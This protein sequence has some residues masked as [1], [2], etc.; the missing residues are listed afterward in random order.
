MKKKIKSIKKYILVTGG[1]GFVGS[2][3]IKNL[4]NQ[5]NHDVI[6]LDNYSTGSK[7]NHILSNKVIYLNDDTK[8][9]SKI[10]SKYKKKIDC[11][12]H[13]G[14]FSRVYQSFSKLEDC[15]D[16]NLKGTSEV[17]KFCLKNKIKVIYSATSASLGNNG[18]DKNLSPYAY[19]KS[20]NLDLLYNLNKWYG[21]KYNAIYFYNV[22]GPK[23][24]S[25]GF[26]ATVIGIFERQYK[27]NQSLTVVRPG[28][29]VRKF[30]NIEDIINGCLFVWKKNSNGHFSISENESYSII[31]IAKM[32]KRKII[33]IKSRVGERYKSHVKKFDGKNTI[34]NIKTKYKIKDYI[35]SVLKNN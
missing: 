29:Q 32:F 10:C 15:L 33:Y 2:H 3:L 35:S 1:A 12:F 16:Y 18:D 4:I 25:N 8:N 34:H 7:K 19:T 17:F 22:Y 9:I 26:M 27:N 23:Q 21:L 28:T 30:T 11:I 5:T 13:F 6:C 31:Q 14:E 20:V 24:I